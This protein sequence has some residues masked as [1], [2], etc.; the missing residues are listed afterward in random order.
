MH[1]VFKDGSRREFNQIL[2]K[3][4]HAAKKFQMRVFITNWKLENLEPFCEFWKDVV[5]IHLV[6]KCS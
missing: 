5:K 3:G 1:R 4:I 6:Q 2:A